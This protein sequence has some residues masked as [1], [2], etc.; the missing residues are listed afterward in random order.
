M[1]AAVT[2]VMPSRCTS[3]AVTGV[4]KARLAR[5]AAFAAASN[6]ST[7]AV[8][9]SLGVA[10]RLGLLQRLGEPR[11]RGVHAVQDEVGRAVHDAE[12]AAHGVAS[13]RFPQRAQQRDGAGHGGL[14]VQVSAVFAGRAVD[15]RAVLGEQGLVRGDHRL[16]ALER[17]QHQRPGRLDPADHLDHD[18]DV[19]PAHQRVGVRGEQGP[20]D[21]L[22]PAVPDPPHRDPRELQPGA[23]P[24]G[25][26]I[27][28]FGQQP[29]HL[30]PDDPA[31]EQGHLQGRAGS[32]H[33][34]S[35]LSRSSIVSRR[36][37]TRASPSLTATTAGRGT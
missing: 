34:T 22:G 17:G 18:V 5:I 11:A 37:M 2:S 7:S 14:V 4:W 31:P 19:R 28:L 32:G 12:H 23:D 16:P 29:G 10:E 25:Q 30:R 20:V 3:A 8:G 24:Q 6:P 21:P 13:Q 36:T 15:L 27:G 35:R 26:V 9:I 33:P 1:S